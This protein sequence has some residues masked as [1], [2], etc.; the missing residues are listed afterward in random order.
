MKRGR[1]KRSPKSRQPASW[2]EGVPEGF[3]PHH[4]VYAQHVRRYSGD[5]WDV[6]N[7]LPVARWRHTQHHSGELPLLVSDLPDSV[8]E[9]AVELI[10]ADR[11][12]SYLRARYAGPDPRLDALLLPD[13]KA[14]LKAA[15]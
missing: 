7:R 14:D 3:D 11:A 5:E 12:W 2:R 9:F 10:G 15:A 13:L 6:R 8:F 1:V 4:I